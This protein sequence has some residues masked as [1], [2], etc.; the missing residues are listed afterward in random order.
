MIEFLA[1]SH[2]LAPQMNFLEFIQNI[3][4]PHLEIL[5]KFFLSVTVLGEVWLPSLI[6]AIWYWCVDS[7]K[8]VY[9]FS[10]FG[11]NALV[12]HL[13]KLTACVYRPWIYDDR[14]TPVDIAM[15]R[16]KSYSMPSGHSATASSVIGGLAF[17][18]RK[19]PFILILLVII[20]L[21][22]G[23][24]R[25]WLGVHTPQDVIAGLT[26]GLI[27]ILIFNKIIEWAESNKTRY[28][29]LAL[30]VNL[31]AVAALIYV[32][33][34]NTYPM[35]YINGKLLVNPH[36]ALKTSITFDFYA[37]GLLNGVFLCRKILPFETYNTDLKTRFIR[38]VIGGAILFLI[39]NYPVQWVFDEIFSFKTGL[40]IQFLS[41][42]FI[43]AIYPLLFTYSEKL[44]RK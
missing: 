39:L 10:L 1:N 14:I 12:S 17:L 33:K 36:H 21:M 18:Y 19:N 27:L 31:F 37:L 40:I 38:G 25:L 4:T 24:S 29:Y 6:C 13:L 22:V 2:W 23:F 8:G 30:F 15:E 3:R 44:L 9:L 11:M 34:F 7:K 26:I 20:V 41:G 43:T 32:L 16:A 42:F 35:D 28:L 5:N